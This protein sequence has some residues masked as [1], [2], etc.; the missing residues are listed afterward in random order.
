ML[1]DRPPSLALSL[2]LSHSRSLSLPHSLSLKHAHAYAHPL[3]HTP[4]LR[5]SPW[6]L[7]FWQEWAILA[8][9]G[10]KRGAAPALDVAVLLVAVATVD[11]HVS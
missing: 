8:V 3:T 5:I 11:L 10:N 1:I 6:S 7:I 2:L 9:E 4:S